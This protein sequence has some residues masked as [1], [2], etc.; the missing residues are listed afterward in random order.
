MKVYIVMHHTTGETHPEYRCC[1][2]D[3]EK[4]KHY[5]TTWNKNHTG[6]EEWMDFFSDFI[7]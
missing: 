1:F 6:N 3:R 2:T 4:A 5:C 7:K